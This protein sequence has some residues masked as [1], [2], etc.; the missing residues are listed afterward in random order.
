[1]L[2]SDGHA[3]S[4]AR[5][6]ATWGSKESFNTVA[7]EILSI[8]ENIGID[9]EQFHAESAPG[10]YEIVLPP[11]A[12][13]AACDALLHTRQVVESAAARHGFRVT[14]HPRPF[15]GIG[16]GCHA[17]MSISSKDGDDAAVYERF[18]GGILEHFRAIFAFTNS[19]PASYERMVDGLWAGGR[20]VT[21][22]TYNKETPLRKCRDS[23]WEI[24]VLDG[25]ANPFLAIAVLLFAGT[26]GAAFR[27]G[28]CAVDPAILSDEQR[29]ALGI[30]KRFPGNLPEAL[31]A[32]ESD[33]LIVKLM[34]KGLAERYVNVKK[35]EMNILH[36]MS[37]EAARSWV[38]ERY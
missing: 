35:A 23:H 20:W 36:P 13:L 1:M 28:D 10:Q 14:L 38:I 32:L 18:Y 9:I 25:M 37:K 6:L 27:W 11:M 30:D 21:W 15:G 12:P 26:E 3:W 24:K 8:L 34:G 31:E 4:M 33:E 22:G 16:N 7:D 5:A 2:R 17:H 29:N 19:H